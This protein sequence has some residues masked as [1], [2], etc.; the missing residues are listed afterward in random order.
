MTGLFHRTFSS[1]VKPGTVSKSPSRASEF[2]SDHS[3][4]Q[5][6]DV[7]AVPRFPGGRVQKGIWPEAGFVE[8]TAHVFLAMNPA[9]GSSLG[10]RWAWEK[11]EGTEEGSGLPW[12]P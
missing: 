11:V 4:C 2:L 12:T 5:V 9:T 1:S 6:P 10:H 3:L 8:D 7:P